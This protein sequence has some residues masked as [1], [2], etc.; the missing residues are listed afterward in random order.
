MPRFSVISVTRNH[1]T[2]L[3]RTYTSL[4]AQSCRDYE[5]VVIDG[6]SADGTADWLAAT[7]ARFISAPDTGIY[8][9]MNK[10]LAMA[11]GD[12]VLFLNAGDTLADDHVLADIAQHDAD[13]LYGDGR[14]GG[15]IKPA[16][17]HTRLLWGMFTYHQA[18]FYRRAAIGPLRYDT[19]YRIAADYKFT[20]QFLRHGAQALY[21]P[22][23]IC[24]FEPGGISQT[25]AATGRRELAR[26]RA[27]LHLCPPILSPLITAAHT[28][29]WRLR[30]RHPAFYARLRL[31]KYDT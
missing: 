23:V 16:H 21:I 15:F 3:R 9:A 10:G 27:E 17:A 2:G 6:A 8:D 7:P 13:L 20:A 12:Y 14:E 4:S 5:W 11:T 18:L 26:I 31:S 19:Q 1:L 22:R 28:L 25:A 30:T 29:F 24:D